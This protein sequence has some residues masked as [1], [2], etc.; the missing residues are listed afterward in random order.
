[1]VTE[2]VHERTRRS[3]V[4]GGGPGLPPEQAGELERLKEENAELNRTLRLLKSAAAML[5]AALDHP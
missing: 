2:T 5:A 1:V 3:P 4:D